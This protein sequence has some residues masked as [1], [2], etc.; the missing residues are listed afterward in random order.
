VVLV[1]VMLGGPLIALARH[2]IF[3]SANQRLREQTIALSSELED[4]LTAGQTIDL[5]NAPRQFP[6][7]RI[8]VTRSDGRRQVAGVRL[9]GPVRHQTVAVGAAKVTLEE[10]AG[11][12]ESKALKVTGLVVG[13][14]MLA[15]ITAVALAIRQ[16]RRLTEPLAGLAARADALGSG[17]FAP[18]SRVSGIPEVDAVSRVLDRSATQ[19]GALVEVQREFA[20]DAAHQLRTPLTGIGLRLEEISRVA[21]AASAQEA[22]HALDQVERLNRVITTLLARARGDAEAPTRFDIATLLDGEADV[23]R[24]VLG[25]A[26]RNLVVDLAS[27]VVVQARREHVIGIMTS[28]FDNALTH[29]TGDVTLRLSRQSDSAVI[30]L[31][32]NGPGVPEGLRDHIFDR[33]VSGHQSTGIGLALAR[34]LAVGE[35]GTLELSRHSPAELILRL[36]VTVR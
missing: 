12:T 7:E 18:T 8:V 23:W 19:I 4:R 31:R 33:S 25:Q 17:D 26:S 16:S 27:G 10:P 9:D 21:D 24:R 5:S 35:G 28:L 15:A 6:G 14:A 1:V 36:P 29:G 22:D 30:S 11:P 2:Q 3:S 20:S 34:S 32:D 13:L